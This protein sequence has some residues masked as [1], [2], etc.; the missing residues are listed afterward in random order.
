MPVVSLT[1]QHYLRE[2]AMKQAD[3]LRAACIALVSA[4]GVFG[5][6]LTGREVKV[7]QPMAAGRSA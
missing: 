1:C 5:I 2:F 6:W 3:E 4:C 7:V